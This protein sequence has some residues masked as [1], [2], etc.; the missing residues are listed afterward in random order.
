MRVGSVYPIFSA[1]SPLREGMKARSVLHLQGN[2][3]ASRQSQQA[4]SER[5]GKFMDEFSRDLR[6]MSL[7]IETEHITKL[8]AVHPA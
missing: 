2:A 3:A 4:R 1:I 8:A 7:M 6:P 5:D